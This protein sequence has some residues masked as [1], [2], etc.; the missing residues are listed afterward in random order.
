MIAYRLTRFIDFYAMK[1][2]REGNEFPAS[3]HPPDW[4]T[5]TIAAF[6]HYPGVRPL[7]AV[8]ECPY[9]RPDG[10]TVASP[11]YDPDTGTLYR[12]T[13]EFPAIPDRPDRAAAQAA[14]ARILAVVG[15]FPF[16]SDADRAVWLAGLLTAIQRPAI[17]GP[18]PGIAFNGNLAGVGKGLL[19][20]VIGI[21][22]TG[23]VAPT[24]AYPDDKEEAAKVKVSLALGAPAIV[25]F[26]NLDAGACYGN[27]ALD[28]AL[29]AFT[30]N[31]RILGTSRHTGEIPLRVSWFL[32]GNNIAPGKDAY[33]RWL[34]CNIVTDLEHPEE[35]ADLRIPDLR[36]YV[37]EHRGELVRDALT[38]LRAHALAGRPS[39]ADCAL[40][41]FED[42]DRQIRGAVSYATGCDPCRTRREAAEESPERVQKL[43]L[44]EGW[45]A[46]PDG[47]DGGAGISVQEALRQVKDDEKGVRYGALRDALVA[48]TRDGSL[49]GVRNLGN[50]IRAMKGA[51][52][53]DLKFEKAGEKQRTALWRVVKVTPDH[54]DGTRP[55]SL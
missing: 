46:L 54:R 17:P 2:D 55:V 15:Q 13:M 25:H 41:S 34:P 20:D 36:A 39:A 53:G 29:T 37:R 16:R 8:V 35:R 51:T 24:S 3:I 48:M 19:V 6:E 33:R 31:D 28:S 50:T 7:L 23:R 14:A 18:V 42:W 21:A 32:T 4:L 10:A 27:S 43:A 49:P 38:I 5:Q 30:V 9:V 44:L 52:L 22:A 26:D 40:G 47:S 11:G 12:P 1:R 45:R